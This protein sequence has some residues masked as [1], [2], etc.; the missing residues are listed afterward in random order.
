MTTG[1]ISALIIFICTSIMTGVFLLL[2]K[3]VTRVMDRINHLTFCV[4]AMFD[5]FKEQGINGDVKKEFECLKK[6]VVKD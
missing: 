1:I 4:F 6:Q 3:Q 5:A 2:K